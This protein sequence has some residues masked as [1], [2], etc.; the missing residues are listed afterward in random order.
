MIFVY[1]GIYIN[2]FR[3]LSQIEIQEAAIPK[4][5][6]EKDMTFLGSHLKVGDQL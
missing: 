2:Q 1:K 6:I 4:K 5:D 3:F